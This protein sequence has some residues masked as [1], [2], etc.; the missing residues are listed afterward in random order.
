VSPHLLPLLLAGLALADE[1]PDPD[2]P[3]EYIVVQDA[4]ELR[5]RLDS[6]LEFMGYVHAQRRG[7]RVVYRNRQRWKP[8]LVVHDDGWVQL[9]DSAV[10][11]D[12]VSFAGLLLMGRGRFQGRRQRE[13]T[14]YEVLEATAPTV[15][16]WQDAI[17]AEA[18][19]EEGYTAPALTAGGLG[20]ADLARGAVAL[21]TGTHPQD[22]SP[23]QRAIQPQDLDEAQRAFVDRAVERYAVDPRVAD[24][25]LTVPRLRFVD[26]EL[27]TQTGPSLPFGGERG[28]WVAQGPTQG[29]PVAAPHGAWVA[30]EA[31][32]AWACKAAR[33]TPRSRVLELGR[34]SGYQA[35]VLAELGA[36]V[37]R[38]DDSEPRLVR[39]RGLL[40][41]LGLTVATHLADPRQGW[42]EDGPYDA[43]LLEAEVGAQ[44][45]ALADQLAERGIL[46]VLDQ[47]RSLRI[48]RQG[49]TLR[50]DH[51]ID[52]TAPDL[53]WGARRRD[54]KAETPPP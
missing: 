10:I 6:E 16:E 49:E 32:V 51:M 48:M 43:I 35:A 38:V 53:G 52:M 33:I 9:K 27:T 3:M 50:E 46:L 24:A 19:G 18:R 29:R 45:T 1:A 28:G 4:A 54:G 5:E 25:L 21:A 39:L 40:A 8:T 7:D 31:Q 13:Q 30:T 36:E 12:G 17:A 47:G 2:A 14:R 23:E 42:S 22:W 20:V 41:G 34:E 26:P 37:H 15:R 11:W 44:P